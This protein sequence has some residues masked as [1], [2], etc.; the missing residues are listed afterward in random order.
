MLLLWWLFIFAC[1]GCVVAVAWNGRW[2][3]RLS[4]GSA[5]WIQDLPRAPIWSPPAEPDYA[6]FR[7]AFSGEGFP[8]P[9]QPGLSIR[10]VL[11]LDWMA[12]DLLFY[13]WPLTLAFGVVYLGLRERRRDMMLHLALSAGAGLTAAA[14]VCIGLWLV[15]GGWGAPAPE[16]FGAVGLVGGIL[17]GWSSYRRAGARPDRGG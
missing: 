8:G 9:D 11:K 12:I 13:L 17:T 16:F 1:L 14:V 10:R 15:C 3:A 6:R 7:E 4:A 5:T 2:E